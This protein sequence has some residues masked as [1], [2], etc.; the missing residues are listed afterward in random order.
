MLETYI[1]GV[2]LQAVYTEVGKLYNQG[3]QKQAEE[4]LSKY[5]DWLSGF[6]LKTTAFI[7]VAKTFSERFEQNRQ[8]ELEILHSGLK[9]V[10]RF[11]LPD[12][13]EL[14]GGRNLLPLEDSKERVCII[15][16]NQVS[17]Q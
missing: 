17:S 15:L 8:R 16:K 3:Q 9:Q 12:L 11:Y 14:N 1:K 6:T 10:T 4:S 2:E 13:D 5:T 7:D